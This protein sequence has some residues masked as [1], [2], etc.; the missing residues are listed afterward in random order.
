[1]RWQ[2]ATGLILPHSQST[3]SSHSSS[4]ISPDWSDPDRKNAGGGLLRLCGGAQGQRPRLCRQEN[5]RCSHQLQNEGA[6]RMIEKYLTSVNFSPV[7]VTPTWSSSWG[8]VSWTLDL[9]PLPTSLSWSWRC[10][11]EVWTISWRTLPMSHWPRR[12]QS[13]KMWQGDWCTCTARTPAIIHR[14][15]TARNVL[16]NSAMVAKIADMGN[17]RLVDMQ[18][19]QTMTRGVPGTPVY[20]PPEAFE[21]PPKYGPKLD[22]FSFGHLALFRCHPAVPRRPPPLHLPRPTVT[23]DQGEE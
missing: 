17:S 20:M 1:M 19:G 18:P 23:S 15:L 21:V 6:D 9:P 8:S 16:L 10:C 13:C 14:D 3:A 22:M 5:V 4:A 11:R 2:T 12:S 7:C